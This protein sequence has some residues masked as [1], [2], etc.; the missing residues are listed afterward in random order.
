MN[1]RIV[2][3][4]LIA[5]SLAASSVPAFAAGSYPFPY[6]LNFAPTSGA[7]GT[8]ITVH[9]SGFTGLN[10]AWIGGGHNSSVYVVSDSEVKVTVPTDATTGQLALLNPANAAW[11]PNSFNV[12]KS[13][14]PVTPPV[15]TSKPTTTPT[16]RPTTRPTTTPTTTPTPVPAPTTSSGT[17]WIYR[18]GVFSWPGDW[19]GSEAAIN[20]EDTAGN[21][22]TKD[23]SVKVDAPWGFWLPY[24]PQVG[25]TINGY[26]VPSCNVASYTSIT[27][28]LKATI[29]GQR[30]SLAI[31]KYNISNGVLTDDTVVGSVPDL[32]PY[33]GNAVVGQFVTYTVPLEALGAAGLTTM[34]KFLLQDQTGSTGQTWYVNNVGFER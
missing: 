5:A 6:I 7:P 26:T 33:G 13:G 21:P 29:P 8:V 4:F 14:A 11:S 10:A 9:G 18:D 2:R 34:Y 23:I 17:T 22:G 16:T 12:A 3:W 25:P 28:Q 30:W 15:A 31:F 32:V 24:C 20:Y 27:M 1:L 19:S